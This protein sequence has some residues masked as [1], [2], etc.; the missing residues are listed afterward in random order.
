VLDHEVVH[1]AAGVRRD[2]HPEV[3]DLDPGRD[4]VA[5]VVEDDLALVLEG[6]RGYRP[7][8]GEDAAEA[9]DRAV[10]DVR[11]IGA[12]G[13]A[14]CEG[15]GEKERSSERAKLGYVHDQVSPC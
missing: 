9:V 14:G 8:I 3:V 1:R 7:G 10:A 5:E 15:T 12:E 4:E 13:A 2:G 6:A 11:L